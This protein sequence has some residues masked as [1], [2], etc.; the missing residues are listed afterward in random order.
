MTRRF[1]KGFLGIVSVI[2]LAVIA[3]MVVMRPDSATG[4]CVVVQPA[5][6]LPEIPEASSLAVSRRNPGILWSHNDSGNAAVLFALDAAGALRG[7]VR[8]PIR[9]RDWED[10]SAARCPAGDCLYIADIG[11]NRLARKRIQIYR[12][13]EPAP[14]DAETAPTEVFSA[15]YADGPHNAEA[16]FVIGADIFVVTRDRTGGL[17]RSTRPLAGSL[18]L[19]LEWFGELGLAAVT[20]AEASPDEASIAVRTSKEVVIY[21]TADVMRGGTVPYGLR[22]PIR[23]LRE[24]QGEGVALGA[25]GML[26][27]ASEGRPWNRAG[28]FISLRCISPPT[29]PA[30]AA[31]P[32]NRN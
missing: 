6:L 26:Y 17:Y 1:R 9:T 28:R 21:R 23:G 15:A 10:I 7:R 27:L 2:G 13:P 3:L 31:D 11:D 4:P 30:G 20:D 19:T 14:G 16:L 8:V 25:G 32:G 5:P 29:S 24:P 22:I 12:V 18:E